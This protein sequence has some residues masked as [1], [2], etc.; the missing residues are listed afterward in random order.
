M[1]LLRYVRIICHGL[2]VSRNRRGCTVRILGLQKLL[3]I[4]TLYR[5]VLDIM[6][7]G[8][9]SQTLR[10]LTI[11]SV[12]RLGNLEMSIMALD[13]MMMELL[14]QTSRILTALSVWRL[15]ISKMSSLALEIMIKVSAMTWDVTM[16][17]SRLS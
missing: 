5:L 1:L 17:M 11:L 16:N 12:W 2:A 9:L 8:L 3:E 15:R 7:M 10:L 13:I 4:L 14:N 6:M